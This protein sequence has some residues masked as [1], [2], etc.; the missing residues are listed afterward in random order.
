MYV[1]LEY[2]CFLYFAFPLTRD[3][4]FVHLRHWR[5]SNDV[6]FLLIGLRLVGL[7]Q[8]TCAEWKNGM[9]LGYRWTES[10]RTR[11]TSPMWINWGRT[12]LWSA[13]SVGHWAKTMRQTQE[14]TLRHLI[15]EQNVRIASCWRASL[16]SD[17]RPLFWADSW[18]QA[19]CQQLKKGG[20]VY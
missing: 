16:R 15:S 20:L 8:N 13:K 3:F 10:V 2:I 5:A 19:L 4:K 1:H 7:C 17:E 18:H 9:K 6:H 14:T 12:C 11:L